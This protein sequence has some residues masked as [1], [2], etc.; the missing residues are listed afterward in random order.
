VSGQG[1]LV[2]VGAV[3]DLASVFAVVVQSDVLDHQIGADY[4]IVFPANKKTINNGRN[5]AHAT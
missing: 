2:L 5:V 3:A 4:L 1:D